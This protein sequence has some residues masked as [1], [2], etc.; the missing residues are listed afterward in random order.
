MSQ[1]SP[2]Q[3]KVRDN[4]LLVQFRLVNQLFRD[5]GLI[6][7]FHKVDRAPEAQRRH[8]TGVLLRHIYQ[9]SQA[10]TFSLTRTWFFIQQHPDH[11]LDLVPT[12]DNT[13]TAAGLWTSTVNWIKGRDL[14]TVTPEKLRL[15]AMLFPMYIYHMGNDAIT[16]RF[17]LHEG[18]LVDSFYQ[19]HHWLIIGGTAPRRHFEF[20][21]FMV[22]TIERA[23]IVDAFQSELM[24]ILGGEEP[25]RAGSDQWNQ[26]VSRLRTE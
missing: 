15:V 16:S 3:Q 6:A 19:A 20:Y 7:N 5:R 10:L 2:E 1:M 13:T 14:S 23:E 22:S 4:L 26:L 17:H 18:I 25:M 24:K 12:P 11:P 8:F 9:M 21:D